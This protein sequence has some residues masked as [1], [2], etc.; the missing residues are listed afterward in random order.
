MGDASLPQHLDEIG[1]RVGLDRIE[2]L[3]RKPLDEVTGGAPRGVR[4]VE[5]NGFVR[6]E[7]ADYSLS[8]GIDVQLK[9]PPKR[10]SMKP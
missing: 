4:A 10:F 2:H 7:V 3:A 1:R 8:V 5:D 9:G 6:T